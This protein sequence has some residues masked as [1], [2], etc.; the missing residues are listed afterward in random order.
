MRPSIRRI[1]AIFIKDLKDAIRDARVLIALVLPLGIGIFY[2]LT[3]DDSQVTT[4]SATVA[5]SSA[6]QTALIEN[7]ENVLSGS[8]QL[9]LKQFDDPEEVSRAVSGE[10]A[11]L[12]LIVP[13]G[14]DAALASGEQPQL[15]VVR[16]PGSSIGG[17]YVLAALDP[18][19]RQMAGQPFPV[20]IDI[21]QTTAAEPDN[22]VDELGL[23]SWSLAVAVIMMIALVAALA[24]PIVLA[25]EFEKKTIDALLL[26]MPYGE[27]VVS[28]AALGMFYIFVSTLLFLIFTGLQVHQ[29][30]WFVLGI[31]MTGIASL[32]L[33]LLL[34]GVFRNANQLNTWSGL[35]LTPFIVPAIMIGQPAPEP[36]ESVAALFPS[37]AGMKLVLKSLSSEPLFSATWQ[38]IAILLAWS[39]VAYL[40]LLWQ[41]KRR[42]A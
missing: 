29:W 17:D 28:K 22:V 20:S 8:V 12:G 4:I 14:F 21:A 6:D 26:A 33:G 40:A 1:Y 5:F 35:F 36:L 23:R 2:N 9:E 27:V 7:L 42:Q 10:D 19:L 34:A 39:A 15:Y 16:S 13:S 25:E 31:A 38:P 30:L 32:G 3:F 37:G 41:L 11:S 18:A 24:I